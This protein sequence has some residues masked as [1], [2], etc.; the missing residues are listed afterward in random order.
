MGLPFHVGANCVRPYKTIAEK[1]T[2][3]QSSPLQRRP[4]KPHSDF[5]FAVRFVFISVH[6]MYVR[7]QMFWLRFF[8]S[9]IVMLTP[10]VVMAMMRVMMLMKL[11]A[12][13]MKSAVVARSWSVVTAATMMP[14]AAD[15]TTDA[16][17]E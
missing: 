11:T 2:G 3:E 9:V 12:T 10:S 5:I 7:S 14:S 13:R 16:K 4:I 15:G 8:L 17:R 6:H 1:H